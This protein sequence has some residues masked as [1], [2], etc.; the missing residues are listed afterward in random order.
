MKRRQRQVMVVSFP[1]VVLVIVPYNFFYETNILRQQNNVFD[2]N[3]I[4]KKQ[5]LNPAADP[6]EG[7]LRNAK[8]SGN[9]T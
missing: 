4:M 5:M 8:V 7:F 6:A 3:Q 1:V 9:V 2:N